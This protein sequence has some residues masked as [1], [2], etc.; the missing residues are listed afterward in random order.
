ML[1]LEYFLDH[2]LVKGPAYFSRKDAE[3]ALDL[4]D[5]SLSATIS[6]LIKKGKM[7]AIH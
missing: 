2:Q 3:K 1:S 4:K 6:R 7:E 5:A